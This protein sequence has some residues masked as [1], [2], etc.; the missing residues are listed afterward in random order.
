MAGLSYV[1]I[2]SDLAAGTFDRTACLWFSLSVVTLQ[3]AANAVAIINQERDVL[4][5]ELSNGARPCLAA[6][7]R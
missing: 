1:Q 3:P 6:D 7:W 4:R 5:R 2:T